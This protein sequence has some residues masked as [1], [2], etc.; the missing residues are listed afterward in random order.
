LDFY[1]E[2]IGSLFISQFEKLFREEQLDIWVSSFLVFCCDSSSGF[3]EYVPN[4]KSL[5]ILNQKKENYQGSEEIKI[6]KKTTTENS[7]KR[8]IQ[9]ILESF[10][11]Y[12]LLCFILQLKDRHN[13][14]ILLNKENRVIHIDFGFIFDFFPGS[15][16]F[17]ADSF[18]LSSQFLFWFGGK[19]SEIFENIREKF[20]RGFLSIRK[21]FGKFLALGRI[22]I[23]EKKD[24]KKNMYR[25]R[26][27]QKRFKLSKS[28]SFFIKYCNEL[29]KES[30]ENWKT[31]QYDKYQHL[32]SGIKQA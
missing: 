25:L 12:S 32:A 10:A 18:K 4:S 30:L 9:N 24:E 2:K 8:K 7:E 1:H 13:G 5:H 16:K 26:K 11:G 6:L 23:E 29:F 22:L 19:E 20:I 27:L 28:D 17:E 3:I 31:L 21:N 14:N 15:L